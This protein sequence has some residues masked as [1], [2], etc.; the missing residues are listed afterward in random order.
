[1]APAPKHPVA[2]AISIALAA[3]HGP[4][5]IAEDAAA[6]LE[7]I[8]VT[9]RKREEPLLAVPQEIQAIS[10]RELERAN[11][12]TAEDLQRFVPSLTVSAITPGRAAIYFRG[13][14]QENLAFIADSS[15]A[16]YLDEQPLTQSGLQPELRIV[17]V[18]RVEA[19]PGP[20]GTLYGASSQSGTLRYI[21]NKPDPTAMQASARLDGHSVEHG[22]PGYELHGMLNLP[23]GSAT[24]IRLV[25]F[26][27]RDAGF[28]DNVLGDSLGGT[29]D[30][31]GFVEEDVNGVDYVGGRAAVRWNAGG[32]WTVD[33]GIVHQQLDAGTYS[34]DN[35]LRAGREL[36][37][38]R[39]QEE[40]R[41]DD[42]TQLALT[43]QGDLRW[44]RLTSA[45]SYFTRDI[46]YLQD[47]TDYE[48]YVSHFADSDSCAVEPSFD[49]CAFAFGPD[50][51]GLGWRNRGTADRLAQEFR[52]QGAMEKTTWLAG[53]FYE[54]VDHGFDFYSRIENYEDTPAFGYWQSEYGVQL[55]T[56]D[57]S[58]YHTGN[59]QVTEQV[60]VFGEVSYSPVE[61]W[62]FTAG[63]RWFEHSRDHDDFLQQPNGRDV[64]DR[65]T[66]GKASTS[67]TTGKLSLQ[68]D[69]GENALLYALFSNGF[70]AGGRNVAGPG[71]VLP[72]DYEPDF[73]DNYELGLKSS[74]GK[75]RYALNL[76]AFRMNWE[77]Y[78][79]EV[80]DPG[81]IY[82]VMVANI[83]DARID[84]LSLAFTA[85]ALDSLELGLNFQALDPRVTAGNSLVGTQ[86]GDR[87][88]YTAREKGAFWLEYR[89]PAEIAGGQLYGRFQW[90]Y[91]GN[92]LNGVSEPRTLQPAY[93]IADFK[94][95]FESGDWEIYAYVDNLNDERAVL[96]DKAGALA[97]GTISINRPRTWGLG[98]E[99]AWE[100]N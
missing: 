38:V 97:P 84:G 50:P 96:F 33:V 31:A 52:L 91:S 44:G 66:G 21:T 8:I 34:A 62:T 6:S 30:N 9:A 87:L 63:L 78:Q 16:V 43:V 29:F 55:G 5:A 71:V 35:V 98:F 67:D 89:V 1:M 14:A 65:S 86:T 42:W 25:G 19:L 81:P 94:V 64:Y 61:R 2:Y 18:E 20:Q 57:N 26:T 12:R 7:T 15:A 53:L 39:F 11:I 28:V 27:A 100:R 69:I 13:V 54:H 88:P 10:E 51:G 45:T 32:H 59:S 90:T 58:D 74:W 37:V 99:K 36:A 73:L 40:F 93:Q 82:A 23:V 60:A 72:L 49:N 76:A 77:D 85:V 24:A 46:A 80:V 75:G 83:G 92:V 17:D 4:S 22:E 41:R 47:N 79:V 70:R 95:G 56:T 3:S 48:F 68:Y